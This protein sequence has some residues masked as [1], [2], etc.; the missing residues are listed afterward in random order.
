MALE[1]I[2]IL[3]NASS[4]ELPNP[5]QHFERFALNNLAVQRKGL[6]QNKKLPQ[7]SLLW[8]ESPL[9]DVTFLPLDKGLHH[10]AA[11]TF[12]VLLRLCGEHTKPV[13]YPKPPAVAIGYKADG[14][15]ASKVAIGAVV[16]AMRFSQVRQSPL[17]KRDYIRPSRKGQASTILEEQ[18]WLLEVGISTPDLRDEIF[19]QLI[20][21]LSMAA[22]PAS[23]AKAWRF[24]GVV[25]SAF[26]PFNKQLL[27]ALMDFIRDTY[28]HEAEDATIAALASHAEKKAIMFTRKR[29]RRR[30]TM[31]AAPGLL[32][33]ERSWEEASTSEVFG[34]SL[35]HLMII[36]AP[37]F[38]PT[39]GVP[40][41]L[42]FLFSRLVVY[43]GLQVAGVFQAPGDAAMS[44]VLK[45][46]LDQGLLSFND[47]VAGAEKHAAVLPLAT[48][49]VTLFEELEDPL[50]PQGLY[51]HCLEAASTDNLK[52]ITT[53]V[54]SVL[55]PAI[56]R[57]VLLFLIAA[58]QGF[59]EEEVIK[60]T[61]ADAQLLSKCFGP[62]IL[63]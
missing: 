2:D 32:D 42:P 8:L 16:S 7:D 61:E 18:K 12:K 56:N 15:Q 24:L 39:T 49:I 5:M 20:T 34:Q 59:C 54:G 23:R 48:L 44:R 36:P 50:I 51:N 62:V 1:Q 6:F 38:P 27:D 52:A 22:P 60:K 53:L 11:C 45:A 13:F 14:K 26:V 31:F 57:R 28:E 41:V 17:R 35:A 43:G 9:A 21:R 47:C 25:L 29:L 46:K 19:C 37:D 3:M 40:A 4:V 63:R 55:L 30:S 10:L 33:V 58:L